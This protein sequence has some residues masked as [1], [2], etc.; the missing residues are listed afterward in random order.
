MSNQSLKS[1]EICC[2]HHTAFLSTLQTSIRYDND[3]TEWNK[4]ILVGI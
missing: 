4:S 1:H 2:K 3:Q